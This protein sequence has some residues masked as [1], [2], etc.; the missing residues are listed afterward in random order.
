M[1]YITF[2]KTIFL[3]VYLLAILL[4]GPQ[5]ALAENE[6]NSQ[7]S[8]INFFDDGLVDT[9]NLPLVTSPIGIA[10]HLSTRYD[11]GQFSAKRKIEKRISKIRIFGDS[12]VDIGNLPPV[13]W[14]TGIVI[15]P[16][17]R[18]DRGRFSNGLLAVEHFSHRLKIDVIPSINGVNLD[19]KGINWGIGGSTTAMSNINPSGLLV[20]GLLGQITE[21]E[22]ALDAA[23]LSEEKTTKR[24]RGKKP[25]FVIW[26]AHNNY[27]IPLFTGAIPDENTVLEAVADINTAVRRLH[28][29]GATLIVVANMVNLGLPPLCQVLPGDGTCDLLSDL[30]TDH[31]TALAEAMNTLE[32]DLDKLKIIQ[33]NVHEIFE[34]IFANPN[35][36]G[37]TEAS[38]DKFG[39]ASG[40]LFDPSP[41]NCSLVDFRNGN[42]LWWDELHPSA[43]MHEILGNA[44]YGIIIKKLKH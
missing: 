16:S 6:A 25:L 28:A 42:I 9:D 15:P 1:G 2:R 8:I 44:L 11:H 27:Y 36:Y 7:T 17:A 30:T 24:R 39:P 34:D 10:I 37:F 33:F 20:A 29:R 5:L 31:N 21:Y 18:Y 23:G 43:S 40:C 4:S 32:T 13:T 3:L 22:G 12:L 41:A 26:T 38:L 14:P 19:D 35:N